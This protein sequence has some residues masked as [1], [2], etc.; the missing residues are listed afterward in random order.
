MYCETSCCE[1]EM[2]GRRFLTAEEKIDKLQ[3]YKE[4]LD[5]EAKG[6]DEAIK[7]LKKAQ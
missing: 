2:E 1:E 6:V 4:W 5:S 7:K 3:K